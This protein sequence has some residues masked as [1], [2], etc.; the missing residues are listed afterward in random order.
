MSV[1]IDDI[2]P[3]ADNPNFGWSGEHILT[4][5]DQGTAYRCSCGR[6]EWTD[7]NN[8]RTH[9]EWALRSQN[10]ALWNAGQRVLNDSSGAMEGLGRVLDW[11][12]PNA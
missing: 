5:N 12:R 2:P 11:C 8:V 10:E 1:D 7:A 4:G 6:S 3:S 9:I